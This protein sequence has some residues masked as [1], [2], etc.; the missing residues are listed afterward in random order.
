MTIS[1]RYHVIDNRTGLTWRI[2]KSQNVARREAHEYNVRWETCDFGFRTVY[3]R[4]E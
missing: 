2:C 4:G 1:T 3:I